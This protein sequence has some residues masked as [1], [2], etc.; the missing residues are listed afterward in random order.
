[1][2]ISETRRIL[3]QLNG[4]FLAAGLFSLAVNI[5]YLASPLYM[6]QVYDR[7]M[8]SGSVATLVML[9]LA[10]LVALAALAGLDAVRALV[11]TRASVRLDRLLAS[12]VIE[13]S[14]RQPE[15]KGRPLRDLD[16]FRQALTG[17]GIQAAFD[18]PWAPIYILIIFLLHPALGF[19]ALGAC[20]ILILLALL[21]EWLTREP[22]REANEAA[23]RN[24]GFTEASLR[25][26]EVLESMG[27]M[28]GLLGRWSKDRLRLLDRQAVASDRSAGMS[29]LIRFVRLALQSLMLG[30]GAY[31]ALERMTSIGSLFAATLLLGRALQPVEQLVGAWRG[32]VAARASYTRVRDMLDAVPQRAAAMSLPRPTGALA[33]EALTFVPPNTPRVAL[34]NVSFQLDPG[35]AMGLIGPSGA[36]KSTLV[37]HIVGVLR[38]TGGAVRLDGADVL[39]WPREQLGQHV[40]Y[41][42]QDIELFSDTVAANIGRLR[43]DADAE[44]VKAA[45]LAGVHDM[46]LRLP[47]G[48]NTQIGEGGAALSGGYRQRIALARAVFGMPSLVVLDEP[49]SNLDSDGDAALAECMA[50]LRELGSTVIIVSHRPSTLGA[51][52]KILYLRDGVIELFGKRDEVMAALNNR[53]KTAVMPR[54]AQVPA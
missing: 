2:K 8:S 25:N 14:V 39:T 15:N 7:V 43:S 51:V 31:L 5:L 11:L 42:P 50:R 32:L 54:S 19:F 26:A 6:L 48:Y 29:S 18:L 1:M 13:A 22:L 27:M 23:A 20:A 49:S 10:L 21:N 40:G 3:D 37:R 9:T 52:N 36:G 28:K 34:R 45:Q 30:L 46:V 33:V 16:A 4:Y 12:R 17:S 41:L 44:I 38:P 35:D 47:E 53:A 24:Y